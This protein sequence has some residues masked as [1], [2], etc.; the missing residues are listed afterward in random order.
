MSIEKELENASRELDD[1]NISLARIKELSELLIPFF[2]NPQKLK[3]L[4]VEVMKLVNLVS[5]KC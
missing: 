5:M 1:P 2:S 3:N 4:S